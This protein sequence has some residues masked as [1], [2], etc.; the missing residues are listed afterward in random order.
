MTPVGI[1][2]MQIKIDVTIT[3]TDVLIEVN[4]SKLTYNLHQQQRC[5]SNICFS[6]VE[7]MQQIQNILPYVFIVEI[8]NVAIVKN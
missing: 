6:N 8:K 2:K 5:K 7:F 1:A 4:N 3:E